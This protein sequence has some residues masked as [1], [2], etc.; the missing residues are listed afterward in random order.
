MTPEILRDIC[1]ELDF[2]GVFDRSGGCMP[3]F[4]LDGHGSRIQ[5][6]FLEYVNNALHLWCACIGV[7]YG[8]D[9]WQVE[10]S[11]EQNGAHNISSTKAK[12]EIV[13]RKEALSLPPTIE[14]Y[15]IIPIINKAWDDSFA[16]V[17]TNRKAIADR[18]WWPYNRNLLLHPK[19]R[20]TMTVKELEKEPSRSIIIPTH[21]ITNFV[22]ISIEQPTLDA[23]FLPPV[24]TKKLN[25]GQ[26]TA[27]RCLDT[28]V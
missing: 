13:R 28:I 26:G 20:A 21:R 25:L 15:E 3:F 22:D 1:A 11:A 14:P 23:K 4:L 16:R 7:P 17:V 2:L 5:L 9:L 8:T 27:M 12:Q 24:D 6:P 18:G 19:I 10:D